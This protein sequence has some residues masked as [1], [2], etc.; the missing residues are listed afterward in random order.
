MCDIEA[1]SP[2]LNEIY[3]PKVVQS[4]SRSEQVVGKDREDLGEVRINLG[5]W[6]CLGQHISKLRVAWDPVELVDTILLSLT[7]EVEMTFDVSCLE[8]K[9]PF[10]AI[11]T[12]AS[13]W[14][15]RTVGVVGKHCVDSRHCLVP[16]NIMS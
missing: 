12:V 6:L 8:G 16:R 4:Q 5:G 11:W 14:I 9:L 2:L 7:Y 13:L 10:L 15:I 3:N 1:L